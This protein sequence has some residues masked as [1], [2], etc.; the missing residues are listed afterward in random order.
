MPTRDSRGRGRREGDEG[1]NRASAESEQKTRIHDQEERKVVNQE[2]KNI[3]EKKGEG[4]G[5]EECEERKRMGEKKKVA[6]SVRAGP[7]RFGGGASRLKRKVSASRDVDV[8]GKRGRGRRGWGSSLE[9][10]SHDRYYPNYRYEIIPIDER[11]ASCSLGSTSAL[12]PIHHPRCC[13]DAYNSSLS[14]LNLGPTPLIS[15]IASLRARVD[16]KYLSY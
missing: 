7:V 15:I 9:S 5:G 4:G 6:Q 10:S 14:K 12:P 13:R 3:Q 16:L 2:T 8:E 11:T 1:K